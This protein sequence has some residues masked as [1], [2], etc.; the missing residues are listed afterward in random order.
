MDVAG[1]LTGRL[2]GGN[3]FRAINNARG[4]FAV[5]R[6]VEDL[7]EW[8]LSSDR[9]VY[10]CSGIHALD[11]VLGAGELV[12][13]DEVAFVQQNNIG[14]RNLSMRLGMMSMVE[15]EYCRDIPKAFTNGYTIGGADAMVFFH[16]LLAEKSVD[17]AYYAIQFDV[18]TKAGRILFVVPEHPSDWACIIGSVVRVSF[19]LPF[20]PGSARPVVSSRM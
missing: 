1:G 20:A 10:W 2:T 17:H 5:G 11:E 14:S 16:L 8:N 19:K 13:T 9:T 12:C 18:P 7:V 6:E 4:R 15:I 3:H